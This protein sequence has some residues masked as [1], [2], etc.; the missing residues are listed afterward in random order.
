MHV[1][2]SCCMMCWL[3]SRLGILRRAFCGCSGHFHVEWTGY[4]GTQNNAP[5]SKKLPRVLGTPVQSK[6]VYTVT[7]TPKTAASPFYPTTLSSSYDSQSGRSLVRDENT[8]AFAGHIHTRWG[9]RPD[10]APIAQ[11]PAKGAGHTCAERGYLQCAKHPKDSPRSFSSHDS[12]KEPTCQDTSH[13]G[14]LPQAALAACCFSL[15][16]VR[17]CPPAE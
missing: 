15:P 7:S 12:L 2:H 9:S 17:F 4:T 10:H 16:R 14:S 3:E 13:S 11:E 6:A 1:H 5:M 8:S